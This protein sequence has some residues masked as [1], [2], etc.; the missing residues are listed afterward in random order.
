MDD[1]NDP[2]HRQKPAI[3]YLSP[4]WTRDEA[5]KFAAEAQAKLEIRGYH[6]GLTGSCLFGDSR[7]DVDLIVYPTSTEKSTR[8]QQLREV[9]EVLVEMGLTLEHDHLAVREWWARSHWRSDDQKTVE[10]WRLG[11]K[12]VDVFHLR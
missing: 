2:R 10:V 12:K 9:A 7:N 3:K 1:E 8:E 6:V 5:L 4:R 11:G